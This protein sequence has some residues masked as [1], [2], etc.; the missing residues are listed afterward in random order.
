MDS[1][2]PVRRLPRVVFC[3]DDKD[4]LQILAGAA[5]SLKIEALTFSCGRQLLDQIKDLRVDV[6]VSDI[7]VP[8][9]SGD[10]L[11]SELT[12]LGADTPLIFLA[13]LQDAERFRHG[14]VKGHSD[15]LVKPVNF[16]ELQSA[17]TKALYIKKQ[18]I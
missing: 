12:S 1:L 6:I 5:D 17:I 4:L 7:N 10:K 9:L 13:G 2:F 18:P 8:G 11:L 16:K 3:D 14:L 15:F